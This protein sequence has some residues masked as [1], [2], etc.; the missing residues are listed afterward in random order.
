MG[1]QLLQKRVTSRDPFSVPLEWS[2]W[3]GEPITVTSRQTQCMIQ[4]NETKRNR[5]P[6]FSLSDNTRARIKRYL[7]DWKI[8]DEK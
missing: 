1:V 2:L 7:A 5:K 8:E 3:E 6:L 4:V